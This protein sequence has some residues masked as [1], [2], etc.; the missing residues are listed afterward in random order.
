MYTVRY[1]FPKSAQEKMFPLYSIIPSYLYSHNAHFHS[2]RKRGAYDVFFN[3]M[4]KKKEMPDYKQVAVHTLSTLL[5][6]Y[7]LLKIRLKLTKKC[8][9]F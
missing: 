3:N 6:I 9:I 1:A 5:K 2:V 7:F 4:L 8:N